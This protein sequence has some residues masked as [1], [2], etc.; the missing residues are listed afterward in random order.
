MTFESSGKYREASG[1]GDR[2]RHISLLE[3]RFEDNFLGTTPYPRS[4]EYLI[5]LDLDKFD[6]MDKCAVKETEIDLDL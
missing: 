6:E 1:T 2:G 3:Q 5:D 4:F